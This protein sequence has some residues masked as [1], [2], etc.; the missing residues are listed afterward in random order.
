M[1]YQSDLFWLASAFDQSL[2]PVSVKRNPRVGSVIIDKTGLLLASGSHEGYGTAHAEQV[3]IRNAKG[4][5]K[6]ATIYVNLAP[7]NHVGK[8]PSCC[9]AIIESGI[10]KVVYSVDDPNPLSQGN[11]DFLK[12]NG[13][14]VVKIK[15]PKKYENVNF[16]WLQSYSKQR[17]YVSA[18]IALSLDGYIHNN[19][20]KN[21]RLTGKEVEREVHIIRNGC[22]AVVTGTGTVL[23]DNPKL[24]VRFPKRI[25][26]KNQ[27]IR[28]V[29]GNKEIP[30]SFNVFDEESETV[31]SPTKEPKLILQD[32][33]ELDV[34]TVLLESG[35]TLFTKFLEAKCIDEL[36]IYLAPKFLGQGL[37]IVNTILSPISD[38]HSRVSKVDIVGNDLRIRILLNNEM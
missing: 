34:R 31:F 35:P 17:P 18:K 37:G 24:N 1:V 13:V 5:T 22:D 6:G 29:V 30:K 14:E 16:R 21:M 20:K 28:Y 4:R 8:T 33:M 7:C 11:I 25:A 36:V 12:I 38:Y 23:T 9:V 27:P 19:I 10:K 3:A 32:L 26:S 15:A 2:K